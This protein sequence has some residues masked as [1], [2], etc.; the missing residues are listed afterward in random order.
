MS[1]QLS[2][3]PDWRGLWQ[4]DRALLRRM[5]D[6]I[7]LKQ[8]CYDLDVSPSALLHA[9]DERDRHIRASW[10]PYLVARAP[11]ELGDAYVERLAAH[12]GLE[13]VP[14]KPRSPE[15]QLQDLLDA[16][17]ESLGPELRAAVLAR[18]ASKKRR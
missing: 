6:A 10:I 3:R 5:V 11:R 13:V 15:Q 1:A 12:R 16:L 2:L 18:A 17:T 9:L 14:A 7:G 8:V 4:E